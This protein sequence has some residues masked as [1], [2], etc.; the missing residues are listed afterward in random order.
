MPRDG[1]TRDKRQFI[2]REKQAE[3]KSNDGPDGILRHWSTTIQPHQVDFFFV[4]SSL[5]S[6]ISETIPLHVH[7]G[8]ADVETSLHAVTV[9]RPTSGPSRCGALPLGR[10][11][12]NDTFPPPPHPLT[13]KRVKGQPGLIHFLALPRYLELLLHGHDPYSYVR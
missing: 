9:W 8:H 1:F 3:A 12:Q 13:P 7:H 4:S 11:K 2:Q 10:H 6:T 5:C